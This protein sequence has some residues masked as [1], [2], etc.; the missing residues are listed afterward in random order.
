[1]PTEPLTTPATAR[2]PRG[3]AVGGGSAGHTPFGRSRGVSLNP[4]TA[5]LV[6]EDKHFTLE[7]F[8]VKHRGPDCFGFTFEER[9]RRP[10]QPKKAEQL[11]VPNSPLRRDLSQGKAITLNDGRVIQPEDVLGDPEP[12]IKLC[13]VGDVSHTGPLHKIVHQADVLAIEATYLDEDKLLAKQ[14]GH[15]TAGAAARLA[16]NAEVNQLI[17]HHVSRRYH[18]HDILSEAQAI[19]PNTIVAN[20]FDCFDIRKGKPVKMKNLLKS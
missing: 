2:R 1:V 19:F 13:F 6:F 3:A 8:S 11:G 14:H 4:M 20:D 5:G 10:F 9:E 16:R 7:S 15:V 17:L 12:G 18:A